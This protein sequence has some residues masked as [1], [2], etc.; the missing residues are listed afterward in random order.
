MINSE[1]F[2][3]RL[4]NK[5]FK[6]GVTIEQLIALS[7]LPTICRIFGFSVAVSGFSFFIALIILALKNAIFSHG[8][9]SNLIKRKNY[10]Y[11]ESVEVKKK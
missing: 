7:V 10:V 6:L 5:A 3:K 8:Q 9:L 11:L 1:K 4:G 2:T